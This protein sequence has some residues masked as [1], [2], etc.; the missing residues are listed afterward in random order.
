MYK[1]LHQIAK[2]IIFQTPN[3][4]HFF[5][6]RLQVTNTSLIFKGCTQPRIQNAASVANTVLVA[7]VKI[8]FNEEIP[9]HIGAKTWLDQLKNLL[10]AAISPR[11]GHILNPCT[12][13]TPIKERAKCQSEE[14]QRQ[15]TGRW[16]IG[17]SSSRHKEQLLGPWKFLLL[18]KSSGRTFSLVAA[19]ARKKRKRKKLLE[20]LW[21]SKW[22][23]KEN[24]NSTEHEEYLKN[25]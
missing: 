9:S 24:Q 1:R 12:Q 22:L 14:T 7:I 16:W 23:L 5:I 10:N 15:C 18:R 13:P 21:T 17:S 11:M 3:G 2:G 8:C 19:Q 25:S 20:A 6:I 4:Q